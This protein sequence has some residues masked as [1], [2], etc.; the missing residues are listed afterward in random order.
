[1]Q[2]TNAANA[3]AICNK[4]NKSSKLVQIDSPEELKELTALLPQTRVLKFKTKSLKK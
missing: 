1:M 3:P 4:I 2:T